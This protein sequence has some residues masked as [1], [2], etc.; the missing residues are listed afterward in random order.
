MRPEPG[1]RTRRGVL[2]V[3]LL[4][5]ALCAEACGA[6]GGAPSTSTPATSS[7][8]PSAPSFGAPQALPGGL[9]PKVLSCGEPGLCIALD[10]SG[11]WLRFDGRSWSAGGTISGAGP[12]GQGTLSLSCAGPS[13]CATDPGAGDQLS[14]WTGHGFG[15]LQTVAATGIEAVGCAPSG[16]CA[17]V[18]G[19]G[20]AFAYSGTS[21]H[22][23]AGDWGSVAAISCVSSAFCMSASGGISRWSASAWSKPQS[24]GATA[25]FTGVSCPSPSFCMAVDAAGQALEWN[26]TAWGA[27]VQM[28]PAGS[29]TSVGPSP[30]AVSCAS[31]TFCVAVDNAGAVLAWEGSSWKRRVVDQAPWTAV[32]CPAPTFCAALD[33]QG[34]VTVATGR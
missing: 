20:N 23:T 27:P 2:G 18:D 8:S 17:A 33:Q 24:A 34:R 7:P 3:A 10:S 1:L 11:R 9:V 13:V 6:G 31:P 14:V 29:A 21:W 12:T 4:A 26:G 16:Y 30:T 15:P 19:E 28:E 32:S 5:V 25:S 22:G